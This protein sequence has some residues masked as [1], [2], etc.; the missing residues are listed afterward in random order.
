LKVTGIVYG[1][2][3]LNFMARPHSPT[4]SLGQMT[5]QPMEREEPG[6]YHALAVAYMATISAMSLAAASD[7]EGNRGLIPPLLVAKAASSAALLYRFKVTGRP[8]YA[9]GAVLDAALFGVTAG[10]NARSS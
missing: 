10:L 7:P 8:G 3:A 1:L 2:G 5:G 9:A 4:D 6:M